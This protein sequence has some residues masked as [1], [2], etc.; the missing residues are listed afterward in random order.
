MPAAFTTSEIGAGRRLFA[1][2]WRF[3]SAH[4]GEAEWCRVAYEFAGTGVG[5]LA[6]SP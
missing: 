5:Q 2:E 4:A 1:P 3:V 6:F